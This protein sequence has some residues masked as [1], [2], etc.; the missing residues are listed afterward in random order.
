[1]HAAL[2]HEKLKSA[3]LCWPTPHNQVNL[4]IQVQ[5]S[6]VEV[7]D[8]G[9]MRHRL[10][11]LSASKVLP[12]LSIVLDAQHEGRLCMHAERLC[13]RGT[14]IPQMTSPDCRSG[15]LGAVEGD[16]GEAGGGLQKHFCQPST[17]PV[18][19]G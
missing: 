16:P 9:V 3:L 10:L 12:L 6:P 17:A 11:A 18:C 14:D 8:D 5:I 7:T 4:D 15:L 1:M 2:L 19:N 13:T